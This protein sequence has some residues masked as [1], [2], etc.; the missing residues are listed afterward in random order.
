MFARTK[1]AKAPA[2]PAPAALSMGVVMLGQAELALADLYLDSKARAAKASAEYDDSKAKLI[3]S[4]GERRVG[5]LPDGRTVRLT[6]TPIG[7]CVQNRR[8]YDQKTL[9]ID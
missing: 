1:K 9:A 6:V 2:A 8:A 4:L 3:D 7:A 5:V